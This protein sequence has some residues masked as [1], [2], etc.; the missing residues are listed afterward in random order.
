MYEY[1][2]QTKN[3]IKL[4][5]Y[6]PKYLPFGGRLS[7]INKQVIPQT[8]RCLRMEFAS[9]EFILPF[10]SSSGIYHAYLP[11]NLLKL[12]INSEKYTPLKESAHAAIELWQMNFGWKEYNEIVIRSNQVEFYLTD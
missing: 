11:E 10:R 1:F 5:M 2:T 4:E 7:K 3:E 9:A 6:A 8:Y 12:R